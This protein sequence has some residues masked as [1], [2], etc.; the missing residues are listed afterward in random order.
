MGRVMDDFE[1]DLARS[2]DQQ[3]ERRDKVHGDPLR[4]AALGRFL[5]LLR[6]EDRRSVVEFG[7]GPGADGVLFTGAGLEYRGLDLSGEHVTLARAKGLHAVVGSVRSLPFE[8]GAF[9][10]GWTMSTLLHIPNHD[11]DQVLGELLRVLKPSAPLAIGMWSGADE[12]GLRAEGA[13][14]PPRFFSRRTDET[15]QRLLAAHGELESFTT[16][17]GPGAEAE[18]RH[19]QFAVLRKPSPPASG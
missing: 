1:A 7:C 19:Y 16:W 18:D 10:A 6:T 15:L 9:D 5:D 12:E 13:H 4:L 17:P 8:D 2:Y 3:A 14:N 11:L